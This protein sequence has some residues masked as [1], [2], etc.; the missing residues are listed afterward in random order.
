VNE[1]ANAANMLSY[2]L[3]CSIADHVHRIYQ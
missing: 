2:E 3:L 1:V